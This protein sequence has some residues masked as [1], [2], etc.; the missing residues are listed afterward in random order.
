[1]SR[2]PELSLLE[3]FIKKD[4]AGLLRLEWSMGN[5]QCPECCGVHQGWLGHPCHPTQDTIGHEAECPLADAIRQ[6]GGS[7]LMM[8]TAVG[9]QR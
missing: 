6:L 9:A 4:L 2:K 5:G 8:P 1:M 7:P 3:C